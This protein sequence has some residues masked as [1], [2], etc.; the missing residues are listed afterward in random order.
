MSVQRFIRLRNPVLFFSLAAAFSA[1]SLCC[2][3]CASVDFSVGNVMAVNVEE[4]TSVIERRRDSEWR[5]DQY[6]GWRPC[7]G[8]FYRWCKWCH[9]SPEPDFRVDDYQYSGK[10]DGE[11]KGFFSLLKGGLRTITGLVGRVNRDRYKVTTGV[12]TIGI[13]GTGY[14]AVLD[15]AVSELAVNTSEGLV[16]VCN[17]FGC[18]ML[19]SGE[20]GVAYKN[21]EPRRTQPSALA[22]RSQRILFAGLFK[23]R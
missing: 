12:A 2:R 15:E 14:N 13:R 19:A 23:R 6:R 21:A 22:Q 18:V 9:C 17:D 11:E 10:A 5:Y 20:S 3:S 4:T 8:A 1:R 16:E 7:A